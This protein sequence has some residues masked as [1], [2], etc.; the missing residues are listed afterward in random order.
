MGWWVSEW[1]VLCVKEDFGLRGKWV[2]GWAQ[3]VGGGVN[4]CVGVLCVKEEI[5]QSEGKGGRVVA[6]VGGWVFC[7][8]RKGLGGSV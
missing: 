2:S 4:E 6:W 8:G 7:V 3:V 1:V 5:G